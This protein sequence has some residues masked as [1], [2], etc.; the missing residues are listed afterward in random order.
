MGLRCRL[1]YH[2]YALSAVRLVYRYGIALAR[3][4]DG[5]A[6]YLKPLTLRL[7]PSTLP[8]T[9]YV[10]DFESPR[11]EIL[12][13]QQP[14]LGVTAAGHVLAHDTDVDPRRGHVA[15]ARQAWGDRGGRTR[16]GGHL[17]LQNSGVYGIMLGV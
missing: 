17:G 3:D 2:V 15:L 10:M 8:L 16:G 12:R 9:L 6:L 5:E 7:K 1:G 14:R 4:T 11:T 13:L